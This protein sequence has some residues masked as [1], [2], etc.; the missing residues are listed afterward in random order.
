[1]RPIAVI[2]DDHHSALKPDVGRTHELGGP[3]RVESG[4]R[5]FQI[6]RRA[7]AFLDGPAFAPEQSD[8]PRFTGKGAVL[9]GTLLFDHNTQEIK[10]HGGIGVH[11]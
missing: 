11:R 2:S 4:E 8:N 5:G 9:S 1:M 3:G 7:F 6:W 10:V